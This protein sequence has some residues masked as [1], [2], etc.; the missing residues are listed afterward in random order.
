MNYLLDEQFNMQKAID[1]H[2]ATVRANILLIQHWRAEGFTGEQIALKLDMPLATLYLLKKRVPELK[3]AWEYAD[4]RMLDKFLVPSLEDRIAN[5]FKFTEKTE[6]LLTDAHGQPLLDEY[7]EPQY[8]VTNIQ[9][10]VA[11]CNHLLK[12]YMEKLDP[13][14]YG[15]AKKDISAEV[16]LSEELNDL[17]E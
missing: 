11:P 9:S 16:E 15:N 7:G 5:G 1:R 3:I 4:T 6:E 8:M 17:A 10:K 13:E 12:W 2:E 14:R